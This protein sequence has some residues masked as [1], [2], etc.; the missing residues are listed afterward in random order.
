M[1]STRGHGSEPRRRSPLLGVALVLASTCGALALAEGALRLLPG[2]DG[3]A[4]AGEEN[5]WRHLVHRRSALPGLAYELVPGIDALTAHGHIRTNRFGMRDRERDLLPPEGGVRIAA[6][7]D[8]FTFGFGV[9]RD[10]AYPARLE[11]LLAARAPAGTPVEVL[12][13]GVGGYSSRD[14]A[15][16]LAGRVRP[17]K[18]RL[19]V[20][21]Y[22]LNDPEIRPRQPLHSH[23]AELPWWQRL[24]LGE[25][26]LRAGERLRAE[27][28]GG[29]NPT[30]ALYHDPESWGSVLAAFGRIGA[31]AREDGFGVLLA[32][33]PLTPGASWEGYPFADLHAQVEAAGR[34]AGFAT[35][36]L[37]PS[38]RA[39]PPASLRLSAED[40]HPNARA[41]ALAAEAICERI[42]LLYAAWCP[43][44]AA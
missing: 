4:P 14:E 38:F 27:R 43:R 10:E 37:L 33:F 42:C 22:V 36:D 15:A 29:G 12:N 20:V 31:L 34:E 17:F 11:A 40:R 21:G 7:G 24:R 2:A 26:L 1:T 19:V 9:E 41:H 6:L 3:G 16:A 5:A 35:L 44:R 32:I 25:L 13:F 18:P 30:R 39:H 23:F 28:Y 8:S